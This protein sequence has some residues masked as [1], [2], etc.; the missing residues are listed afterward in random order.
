MKQTDIKNEMSKCKVNTIAW[1]KTQY[2][3]VSGRVK[4]FGYD[5]EMGYLIEVSI[6]EEESVLFQ[7]SDIKNMKIYS[8]DYFEIEKENKEKQL[9]FLCAKYKISKLEKF[10]KANRM[11]HDYVLLAE[12]AEKWN[13]M[14]DAEKEKILDIFAL[15]EE[16]LDFILTKLGNQSEIIKNQNLRLK[17]HDDLERQAQ[18]K[19]NNMK[20]ELKNILAKS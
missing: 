13:V 16:G 14:S 2:A 19:L 20:K 10:N 11:K 17:I 18:T 9:D 12:F 1:I 3:Y 15:D 4:D 6:T 5:D 7:Q 8:E